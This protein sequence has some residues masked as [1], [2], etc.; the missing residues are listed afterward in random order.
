MMKTKNYFPLLLLAAAC[1]L[2]AACSDDNEG[3]IGDGGPLPPASLPVTPPTIGQDVLFTCDFQA[4]TDSSKWVMWDVDRL[5]PSAAMQ[6]LGFEVGKPWLLM[7]KDSTASTNLYAGS[8]SSYTPA[9]QA[10]DWLVTKAAIAVPDSGYVLTWNSQA[11]DPTR[12]DGIKVL[13]STTGNTPD[14]F[15]EAPVFE[16]EEEEAGATENTYGEWASHADSLNAY[17]GQSIYVAFVNGSYDKSV[18]LL[19]DVQV[20]LKH[21]A[22]LETLVVDRTTE[23]QVTVSAVLTAVEQ[24][25]RGFNAFFMVDSTSQFGQAFPD[26]VIQPGESYTFTLD[27]PMELGDTYGYTGYRLWVEF[28]GLTEVHDGSVAHLAFEPMHKVVIEE[29]TGQWCGYCPMGILSFEYLKEIYPDQF[30]GIAVHNND[31]MMV[32]E[33]DAGLHFSQFPLG[34]A[35]RVVTC[36]PMTGNYELTAN[37]GNSESALLYSASNAIAPVPITADKFADGVKTNPVDVQSIWL[38]WN[39]LNMVLEVKAQDKPHKFHFVE[40]SYAVE[41]NR[42]TVSLTLYHDDGDDVQAY[43]QRAYCSIPLQQYV[44]RGIETVRLS[45]DIHTYA[46]KINTYQFDYTPAETDN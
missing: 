39:Y 13:V 31:N 17:A 24:E 42:A 12:R 11:L 45:I 5:T 33:Y 46:G 1:G 43:T 20:S 8:T 10:E 41:G 22:S 38:G 40:D 15:T 18:L 14:D 21:Y 9:G 16:V 30:I 19:D 32:D 34:Y 23:G 7:L 27:A 26:V 25:I 29:G 4:V 3:I 2:T 28:G 37:D 35:N 6:Q 44:T 36:Q